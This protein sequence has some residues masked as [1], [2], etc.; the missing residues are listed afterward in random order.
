MDGQARAASR[1]A[2]VHGTKDYASSKD[3]QAG[4]GPDTGWDAQKG[5]SLRDSRNAKAGEKTRR[6]H[7]DHADDCVAPSAGKGLL[8]LLLPLSVIHGCARTV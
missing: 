1:A 3:D 7:E 6:D 4:G 8:E 2:P 5:Y